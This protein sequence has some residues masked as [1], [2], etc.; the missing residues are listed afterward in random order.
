MLVQKRSTAHRKLECY[1]LQFYFQVNICSIYVRFLKFPRFNCERLSLVN[2]RNE[3]FRMT[4]SNIWMG[5]IHLL[6]LQNFLKNQHFLPPDTLTHVCVSMGK[7]CLF[8]GK[9]CGRNM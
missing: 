4:V 6:R 7:K 3:D 8:F 9:F 2:F 5:I 1:K